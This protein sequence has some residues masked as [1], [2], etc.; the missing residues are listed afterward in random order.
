MISLCLRLNRMPRPPAVS[1]ASSRPSTASSGAPAAVLRG[2]SSASWDSAA[3]ATACT[4]PRLCG[5]ASPSPPVM[6]TAP[7]TCPVRGSCTGAAAQVQGWTRRMKCSAANTCTG[8]STATAVPGA[9]VPT[10]DSAQRA[11][12]TKFIRSAFRRVAG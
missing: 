1:R 5:C 10:A 12:G 2:P 3:R 11:P 4:K 7:S 6:S 8:R 9:F